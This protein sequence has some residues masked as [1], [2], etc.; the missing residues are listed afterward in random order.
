[1]SMN[2]EIKP[3]YAVVGEEIVPLWSGEVHYWRIQAANWRP[4]LE[5]VKELGL[6]V[7]ATYAAW[8][9]HEI[10]EAQYDFTGET[11]PEHNLIGFLEMTHEMGLKVL[12]RPGPYIYSEWPF[13]GP[14]EEATKY[15]RLHP[16]FKE[17]AT[18]WIDA[19]SEM[20][21]PFQATRGGHII[22]LQPDNEPYPA[23]QSQGTEMGCFQEPGMFKEWLRE[24][25]GDDIARLNA[26][27]SAEYTDFNQAPIHWEEPY[28]N[29]IDVPENIRLMPEA[30]YE[31]RIIDGQE[32]VEWF[33]REIVRWTGDA[34]RA[35]G[36]DIPFFSN[37]WH[38]YAQNFHDTKEI[39]PLCG[40]DLY[41]SK[42]FEFSTGTPG[43]QDWDYNLEILKV[44]EN[45]IGWGYSA[46]LECGIW[47]GG[48]GTGEYT[49]HSTAF[50]NRV[51]IANG[52]KGWNWYV[53]VNR[54]NWYHSPINQFGRETM[55]F[56]PHKQ[57]M[58]LVKKIELHKLDRKPA[59]SLV[60]LRRQ[61]M[62]DSGNWQTLWDSL[63]TTGIDFDTV[64]LRYEKPKSDL[65]FYGGTELIEADE[66]ENL[67]RSV[68]DG[69]TVV[70]FNQIPRL[71]RLG[72]PMNPFDLPESDGIRP[73]GSP[74]TLSWD[75]K[76]AEVPKGGHYGRYWTLYFDSVPEGASPIVASPRGTNVEFLVDLRA[77]NLAANTYR[78]GFVKA[79]GKGK[80]IVLGMAPSPAA[81]RIAKEIAG[82]TFKIETRTP[83]TL[84]TFWEGDGAAY[85]FVIN[86]NEHAVGVE[87]FVDRSVYPNVTSLRNVETGA[88]WNVEADGRAFVSVQGHEVDVFSLNR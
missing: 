68:E 17:M 11:T 44:Q 70:I 4:I 3:G 76:T 74:F 60:T 52:L 37:G 38:V 84:I 65:V 7:I 28:V 72:E 9:F 59:V 23:I 5:K 42:Y 75:G 88:K 58:D 83:G 49:P 16:K 54:D 47:E 13:G 63:T 22:A 82:G 2:V 73:I 39:A 85:A 79:F 29:R 45:N 43:G 41:P 31:Q 34:Y 25:Y 40:V 69:A 66:A 67:R 8:N 71:N 77:T 86:R 64:D 61:R 19:I 15:H 56:E 36:I 12:I 27:W 50:M 81:V 10:G 62:S 21:A 30:R 26:A 80:V 14:P 78:L 87:L 46:E 48:V 1:M 51:L 55:Y 6:D 57:V 35:A 20:L 18:G 33:A 24:R 53:I 32:W